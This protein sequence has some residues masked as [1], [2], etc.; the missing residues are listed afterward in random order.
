L[1]STAGAFCTSSGMLSTTVRRP[2]I[3]VVTARNRS[4]RADC[5]VCSRSDTAPTER[6]ISACSK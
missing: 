4:A 1:L 3:A 2:C 5:G 6:T